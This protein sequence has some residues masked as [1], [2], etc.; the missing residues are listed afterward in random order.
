M[1]YD[2]IRITTDVIAHKTRKEVGDGLLQG[3]C[4]HDKDAWMNCWPGMW[5]MNLC[6][7]FYGNWR[8]LSPAVEESICRLCVCAVLSIAFLIPMEN[9]FHYVCQFTQAWQ[10]LCFCTVGDAWRWLHIRCADWWIMLGGSMTDRMIR[11]G[12]SIHVPYTHCYYNE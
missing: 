4:R 5:P 6:C 3:L 12:W 11:E 7:W 9:S 1:M 2:G 10:L 8:V